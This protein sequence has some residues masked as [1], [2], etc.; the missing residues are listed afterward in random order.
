MPKNYFRHGAWECMT[1]IL[2]QLAVLEDAQTIFGER[3]RM[4][5]FG[6]A[7]LRERAEDWASK[8]I[9]SSIQEPL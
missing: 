4:I 3:E 5:A 6:K 1:L 8:A 2:A 7:D 9:R